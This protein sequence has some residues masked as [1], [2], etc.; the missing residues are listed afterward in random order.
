MKSEPCGPRADLNKQ[1]ALRA[2]R[3]QA[4][5]VDSKSLAT[6]VF[7]V[8]F[9]MLSLWRQIDCKAG[10]LVGGGDTVLSSYGKEQQLEGL[11][12]LARDCTER[13]QVAAASLHD[14]ATIILDSSPRRNG[15][16]DFN[17]TAHTY[18]SGYES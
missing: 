14:A 18:N 5:S 3:I 2:D 1:S 4:T 7:N 10:A 11:S 6:F 17:A 15:S 8:A 16:P 13:Q 12:A 9:G